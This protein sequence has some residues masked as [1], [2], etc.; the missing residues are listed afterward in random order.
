MSLFL[1][2]KMTLICHA[3]SLEILESHNKTVLTIAPNFVL[4]L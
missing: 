3:N 4:Y 1:K 2:I